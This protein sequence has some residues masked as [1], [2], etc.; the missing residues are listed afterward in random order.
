MTDTLLLDRLDRVESTL[1]IQ[2]LPIRYAIAID[3]RDIDGWLALFVDDVDC[4]RR[5]RGREALRS[6]IDPAIRDFYRS[7]HQIVGHAIDFTDA[8]HA[9]GKVYCRAEHEYGEK[10]IVQAI[11]YFDAYERRDG[12]WYFARREEDFWYSADQL[13][14]PQQADFQ[15]WPGPAPRYQPKMMLPRFPN[16]RDFWSRSSEEELRGATSKPV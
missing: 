9:T 6:F 12:R 1:A 15:H 4:G 13:E 5:G 8:D 16:W 3:S 10:W 7:V 14:R 11:C 2:Q